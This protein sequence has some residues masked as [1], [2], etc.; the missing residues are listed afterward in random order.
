MGDGGIGQGRLPGGMTPEWSPNVGIRAERGT[1]SMG[2]VG[3]QAVVRFQAEGLSRARRCDRV[4]TDG[5][6]GVLV[7][8]LCLCGKR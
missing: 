8:R 5:K 6:P 3:M 2:T 4:E 7:W 1:E